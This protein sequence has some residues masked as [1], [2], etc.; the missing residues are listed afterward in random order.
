MLI[1]LNELQVVYK[2]NIYHRILQYIGIR[3]VHISLLISF[4]MVCVCVFYSLNNISGGRPSRI[5][6]LFPMCVYSSAPI[7][8]AGKGFIELHSIT[9]YFYMILEWFTI[10]HNVIEAHKLL[11][12][13]RKYIKNINRKKEK[14]KRERER[15]RGW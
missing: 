6:L 5:I 8:S 7:N 12:S 3:F 2:P 11:T 13:A 9:H 10:F 1:G 15:E 4:H 14:S